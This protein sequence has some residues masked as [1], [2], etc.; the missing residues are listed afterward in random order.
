MYAVWSVWVS[1]TTLTDAGHAKKIFALPASAPLSKST[2]SRPAHTAGIVC[3][4]DALYICCSYCITVVFCSQWDDSCCDRFCTYDICCF[5]GQVG[6]S[7]GEFC[8]FSNGQS[9]CEFSEE[10]QTGLRRPWLWR[11]PNF[12]CRLCQGGLP[13][14]LGVGAGI[15]SWI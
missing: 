14:M 8:A 12:L 2:T 4:S 3:C 11:D 15:D 7:L 9:H 5:H 1:L 13:L 6:A 10:D